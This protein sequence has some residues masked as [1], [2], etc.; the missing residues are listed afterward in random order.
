MGICISLRKNKNKNKESDEVN[1]IIK[2]DLLNNS[3]KLLEKT[4]TMKEEIKFTLDN[5]VSENIQNDDMNNKNN[6]II[7][8]KNLISLSSKNIDEN[9]EKTNNKINDNNSLFSISDEFASNSSRKIPYSPHLFEIQKDGNKTNENNS[10]YNESEI[11]NDNQELTYRTK[12][13]NCLFCGESFYSIREYEQHFNICNERNNNILFNNVNLNTIFRPGSSL[14]ALLGLNEIDEQKEYIN[15]IYNFEKKIWENKGKIYLTKD[16]MNQIGTLSINE[17]KLDKNFYRKRIW[18]QKKINNFMLDNT[19]ANIPI[20]ISRQN[21]LEESLN[22]FMTNSDLNFY[23]KFQIFFVDENAHDEGGVEREWYSE[24][25]EEIFL[26]KNNFFKKIEEKSEAKGT[27]FIYSNIG[28]KNIKNRKNYFSFFGTLFAK[29]LLDKI[30]IPYE[31]NPIILK[32]ILSLDSDK[33]FEQIDEEQNIYEL[34]DIKNYDIEIYNSLNKILNSNLNGDID[35][36]FTW[37]INNIEIELIKDGKNIL[38]NNENKNLFINKVVELIC[39]ESIKEELLSFKDG[40]ISVIP[41]N[42]IN[43]FS[44]EEFNFIL[45]GQ[46]TIN[47]KDW[48]INT[49]YKGNF[50]E[51]SPVIQMFWEVLSELNNEKLLLF[52]KFCTGSIRIPL[53]G[54]SSLPGPKNKIIKFTIEISKID[55]KNIKSP[56]LIMAHTCFNSIIIPEYNKIEDMRKAINII[57]ENDTNYFGLE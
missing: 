31:L 6:T 24:L 50:N 33:S 8:E 29:A 39:F 18:L 53:D 12:T 21:V 43:I 52:F 17:I 13:I 9:M 11:N 38:V 22:H 42:F 15:W 16:E 1:K 20:I 45:S 55:N 2:I 4:N 5:I 26:E 56:K 7:S 35:I 36:F 41:L 47:L 14:N 25:F 30:L 54:F 3:Q 27:Y 10:I 44:V 48:K 34:N 40:F 32:F 37:N 28:E 57:L 19:K 51:K 23:R 49:I 46:T